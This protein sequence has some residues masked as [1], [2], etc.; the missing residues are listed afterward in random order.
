MGKLNAT[1][2]KALGAL[3]IGA[4]V[5]S[6]AT[7]FIGTHEGEKLRAYKDVVGVPTV[8]YGE[9]QDVKMGD[10]HTEAECLDMLK[11][12]VDYFLHV[13]DS[14]VHRR[15]PDEMRVALTSFV[16]NVGTS[17]F[18]HSMLMR[19]L[20]AGEYRKACD[21]LPRWNK[22][23]RNTVRGLVIRREAERQLCLIGAERYE[24]SANLEG[25]NDVVDD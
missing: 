3:G 20:Q 22:A 16:Y 2:V 9:T 11:H 4:A 14:H 24:Q 13:V 7:G 23:G 19:Y 8:C 15:L 18:D 17:R 1:V 21:E 6:V 10:E 25:D 5:G 12:H